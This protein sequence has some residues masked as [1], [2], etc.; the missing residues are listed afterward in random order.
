MDANVTNRLADV[1]SGAYGLYDVILELPEEGLE[2]KTYIVIGNQQKYVAKLYD[3]VPRALAVAQFQNALSAAG[4]PVPKIFSTNTGELISQLDTNAMVLCAFAEG[5]PMGWS[6]D[7]ASLAGPLSADMGRTVA[8]MHKTAQTLKLEHKLD[9]PLSVSRASAQ[10]GSAWHARFPRYNLAQVRQ[11]MIHGD[12]TRENIFVDRPLQSVAA[13]IDFGDAH[14]DYISYDIATLLTHIY[15]SKTWGIDFDGI[16][17]FLRAYT[18]LHALRPAELQTI[19]PFMELRN[20]AL[21]QDINE[22]THEPGADV[23]TLN[24]ITQSLGVKLQLLDQ[25]RPE[26]ETAILGA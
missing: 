6:D 24:S 14:Y 19:L 13:I 8:A 4:L 23:L 20:R 12:L 22:R 2:N 25:R 15:V 5:T 1:L 16:T 17:D 3:S 10:L 11:S 9:H 21:L 18:K 26:L 7:F